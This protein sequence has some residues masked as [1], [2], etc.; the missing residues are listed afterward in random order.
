MSKNREWEK[1]KIDAMHQNDDEH[2]IV[3]K[4][5]WNMKWKAKC[6]W[7]TTTDNYY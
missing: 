2:L 6:A 7:Y 4:M 5:K 3:S 1:R